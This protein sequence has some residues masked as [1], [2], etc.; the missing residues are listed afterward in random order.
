MRAA[1]FEQ[2]FRERLSEWPVRN[3][4]DLVY[5]GST[6]LAFL[7]HPG[8]YIGVP[9]RDGVETRISRLGG[10]CFQALVELSHLG[11]YA[12]VRFTRETF[13][14]KTGEL[15]Y[16]EQDDPFREED[17]EFFDS[18]LDILALEQIEVLPRDVLDTLVP[19]LELDVT[20]RG[21]VTIYH[22]LFDEE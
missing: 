19:D 8:H 4:T 1:R 15:G 5:G 21:K 10:E 11:P 3:Q 7:L 14:R 12:R 9:T 6:V 18:L 22:C 20:E 16:E 2:L 13:D 17:R